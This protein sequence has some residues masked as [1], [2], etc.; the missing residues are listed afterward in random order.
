MLRD[1]AKSIAQGIN[2]PQGLIDAMSFSL[3]SEGAIE[4]KYDFTIALEKKQA[5]METKANEV[6][7]T[8]NTGFGAEL[9]NGAV[10]TTDFIDLAPKTNPILKAFTGYHGR[11]LSKIQKVPV[12]GDL[13]LHRIAP[14]WTTGSI[15]T[16]ITQGKGKLPTWDVTLN[17]KKYIFS[18]DISDEEARFANVVDLVALVQSKLATSASNTTVYA[19][20]NGDPWTVA[21]TNINIIDGTPASD[22]P[23]LGGT[24]LVKS[25]FD[26]GTATDG[27]TLTFSDFLV[28]LGLLWENGIAEDLMWILG[29]GTNV[30]ALG[31]D[32]FK[33]AYINGSASTILTGKL[34]NF[35]GSDVYVNRYLGKANAAG[36]ISATAGN[37]TKGRAI[38]TTKDAVQYGYNGDYSLE[39]FRAPGFGWQVFG[40]FYMGYD[41]VGAMLGNDPKTALLYNL[42]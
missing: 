10:G 20:I 30:T 11:N 16:Q 39:L 28:S 24:G 25:A 31:I 38:V 8:T 26:G 1:N 6:M 34:P 4:E 41:T 36:K 42:S 19:L 22:D 23:F 40:Y 27:G 32:E 14:E 35:L 18:V 33:Q 21:N 2:T 3:K 13:P 9:I 15:L 37:N 5:Q 12:I 17:Q 7:H 29:T